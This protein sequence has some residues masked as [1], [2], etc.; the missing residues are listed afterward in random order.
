MAHRSGPRPPT[1]RGQRHDRRPR[2]TPTGVPR[3][4]IRQSGTRW[5][6]VTSQ[7]TGSPR[8]FA[9]RTWSSAAAVDTC[10][11]WRRAPGT[12]ARTS[13]SSASARATAADSAASGQPRSPRTVE[14]Y[15]S[16]ASAPSVRVRS[17]AC[18][19][20]GRPNAPA[21]ARAARRIGADAV[22]QA[23]LRE[24]DHA[25]VRELPER[26]EL[27]PSPAGRDRAVGQQLDRGAGGRGGGPDAGKDTRLVERGLR[28]GHG[29]DRRE[30]AVR[31]GGQ[32]GRHG[33]GVLVARLAEVRMQVDEP[34]GDH[35]AVGLDPIGLRA[36]QPGDRLEDAVADDDLA[37][38]L[39]PDGRID[40][41]G[42]TDLEVGA[43]AH[44]VA[45]VPASR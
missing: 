39:S 34:R 22:G 26:R 33:L 19:T 4:P 5:W 2:P 23:V 32:P 16:F 25:G 21:Y 29:T 36:F 37:R 3:R 8:A 42:A 14:T 9:A 35:H 44:A 30:A 18:S 7:V 13:S 6:G 10:V 1:G 17:S 45:C 20:I 15:P 12:S 40:E 24:A 43:G 31:R 38:P 28:V 11:R 27:R 41:P